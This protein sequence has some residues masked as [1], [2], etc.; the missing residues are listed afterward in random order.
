M[1]PVTA[2]KVG[3]TI[4]GLFGKK[5]PKKSEIEKFS[6]LHST[7]ID[8]GK[9]QIDRFAPQMEA[10][11]NLISKK[12][13][14]D[15]KPHLQ[16]LQRADIAQADS[17]ISYEKT[18]DIRSGVEGAKAEAEAGTTLSAQATQFNERKVMDLYA[19]QKMQGAIAGAGVGL[20]GR[21]K[22]ASNV[23]TYLAKTT[24][25]HNRI[26]VATSMLAFGASALGGKPLGG[27]EDYY[28]T[29]PT[30]YRDT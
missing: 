1:D 22:T 11:Q 26:G 17:K 4:L 3:A 14:E 7:N 6:K 15:V 28:P 25:Q 5:R 30:E 12:M 2:L 9:K 10:M 21:G 27:I 29:K 16:G 20:I 19:A 24:Q 8:F 23:N 18:R 13:E